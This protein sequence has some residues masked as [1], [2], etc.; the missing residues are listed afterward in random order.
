MNDD[1]EKRVVV[2]KDG[3][4]SV[5]MRVRFRLQS[6]ETVHWSTQIKK[7]PSLT[8]DSLNQSQPHYLQQG[9]SE[10]CSDPD[11][12]SFEPEAVDCSS[13]GALEENHCHCCYRQEQQ[14]D[15]WKNPA[16]CH[17]QPVPPPH[18]S[19][20]T[21]TITRHTH[22]SSSSSSCNSRRVVRCRARL[23]NCGDA[24]GSEHN[25]LVQEEMC[26]TEHVE[27]RVEQDGHVEVS[28]VSQCC[29]RSEVVAIENNLQ[30]QNWKS[31]E[32]ERPV[33][34]VSTS[35]H[36]LRELKGDQDDE[37]D[38]L[39][40]SASR[41]CRSNEST[42]TPEIQT[43]DKPRSNASD[44]DQ[45][46]ECQC[47]FAA[48]AIERAPSSKSKASRASCKSTKE[49]GEA[50]ENVDEEVVSG[51]FDHSRLSAS[52]LQSAASSTC[53]KCGGFKRQAHSKSNSRAS[54]RSLSKILSPKPAT[55][56]SAEDDEAD[57]AASDVSTQSNKSNLTSHRSATWKDGE[58][59]V[60]SAMSV[61][62]DTGVDETEDVRA[63]SATLGTNKSHKSDHN[64]AT[65]ETVENRNPSVMSAKSAKSK[66]SNCIPVPDIT[67][68]EEA[69]GKNTSERAV[70]ALSTKSSASAKTK[71]SVQSHKPSLRVTASS[72]AE[73]DKEAVVRTPSALSVKSNAS[74]KK[75]RP[76]SALSAKST[77]S[78]VSEK[79]S[80]KSSPHR[81]CSGAPDKEAAAEKEVQKDEEAARAASAISAMSNKSHK[82]DK[83]AERS[84][85]PRSDAGKDGEDRGGTAM[86]TKSTKSNVSAKSN[87]NGNVEHS[88]VDSGED[89][90]K[91]EVRAASALSA[92]SALSVKSSRTNKSSRAASP[93]K[94]EEA[95]VDRVSSAMSGKSHTSA[96]SQMSNHTKTT[97]NPDEDNG[98]KSER[99]ASAI[100]AKSKT[101]RKLNA[102]TI[103]TPEVVNAERPVSSASTKTEKSNMSST[104][105]PNGVEK[106][107]AIESLVEANAPKSRSSNRT[108]SPRHAQAL[109]PESA[110]GETRGLSALSVRSGKSAKSSRSKCSCGATSRGEKDNKELEENMEGSERAASV[111]SSKRLK[112]DL[113]DTSDSFASVSLVLPEDQGSESGKSDVSFCAK[114]KAAT[115]EVPKC[116][117]ENEV[118]QTGSNN[119]PAMDI[120]T[121]ETPGGDEDGD[122]QKIRVASTCSTR[123]TYSVKSTRSKKSSCSQC[124]KPTTQV[125]SNR[126]DSPEAK[127]SVKSVSTIKTSKKT[128]PDNRTV[129]AMSSV[130][131]KSE[132]KSLKNVDVEPSEES[133]NDEK[134][135]SNR[136]AKGEEESTDT[137]SKS[138]CRLQLESAASTKSGSKT[139]SKKTKDDIGSVQSIKSSPTKE[140]PAKSSSPAPQNSSRPGSKGDTCSESILSRSLS[141]ADLLKE[142]M[143]ATPPQSPRSK[144]SKASC[145]LRSEKCTKSQRSKKED[146]ALTPSCLPNVSP[147]EV[148]SDWLRSIPVESSMLA[149]EDEPNV[150][151]QDEETEEKSVEHIGMEDGADGKDEDMAEDV[152]KTEERVGE[153]ESP[154]AAHVES[155]ETHIHPNA[156]LNDSSLPRSWHSS[157]AVMKVLLSSSLGRC[158]SMPE[159]SS[160]R[161]IIEKS[162][163]R[164]KYNYFVAFVGL[165][166]I[167]SLRSQT[168]HFGQRVAGLC[169]P[170]SAH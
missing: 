88:S 139:V 68:E 109:M 14:Y 133:A 130:S 159:V 162:L 31:D 163:V 94:V 90:E 25:Q 103:K 37:E 2:N 48:A 97:A 57:D 27:H 153:E 18:T 167:P 98:K 82:S 42:P 49:E 131:A 72:A 78:H 83:T 106:E 115:P 150:E 142:A 64:G 127:G 20:E 53:P 158:R 86:S 39:P 155:V 23:T 168:Q 33:T 51:L 110:A 26:V 102:V 45:E 24:S 34:A 135:S 84:P 122:K 126:V 1:I 169:G 123:S 85:T 111:S 70:S 15:L 132:R 116:T 154:E 3:S 145:K 55:P 125:D 161:K 52:S 9:Q 56:H 136:A 164:L 120:P 58:S 62:S 74:A 117:T 108:L 67:P 166:G 73:E 71:V 157:A 8:N 46:E 118:E 28:R 60:P 10:S 156:L 134:Q 113:E 152:K 80:G 105:K 54:N 170:A 104:S 128:A 138:S 76:A 92:K 36:V 147:H 89:G 114:S 79:S 40:L 30:A 129:S 81:E 101:S 65:A 7:S 22:S 144:A 61:K 44:H 140:E 149:L 4:L 38:E 35:S 66:S 43:D 63:P 165:S 160:Q 100:S 59:R 99:V 119:P 50:A 32:E 151:E 124:G 16:H 87:C 5:E 148:V 13:Q 69:E 146:P 91:A 121:I 95:E 11:S 143:A 93:A 47:E 96:K 77:K 17:K 141:A 75:S 107:D 21:H 12:T 137:K 29:S 41:C 112:R 6:D 19:R